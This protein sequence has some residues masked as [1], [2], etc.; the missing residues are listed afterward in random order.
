MEDATLNRLYAEY[1]KH[2]RSELKMLIADPG[3]F[4]PMQSTVGSTV[5]FGWL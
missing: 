1:E 4:Q 5:Y 2:N 3:K